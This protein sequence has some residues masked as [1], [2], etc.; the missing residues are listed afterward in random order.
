MVKLIMVMINRK[1]SGQ[2]LV[3]VV[4]TLA[5][6]SLVVVALV[7]GATIGIRNVQFSRNQSRAM[8]LNREASE[9]LRVEKR[10]SWSQLWSKGSDGEGTTYCFSGLNFNKKRGC[11]SD[12]L[13]DSKFTREGVLKQL[14]SED[15]KLEITITTNWEDASG[16]HNET[17]TTYLTKY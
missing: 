8:E 5:I 13:I 7:F 6:A 10:I 14:G 4:V 1:S 16:D 15:D 3:E 2:S 12:E 17:I 11:Y 9:W